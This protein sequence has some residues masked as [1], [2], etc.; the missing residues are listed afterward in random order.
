[1]PRRGGVR[2]GFRSRLSDVANDLGNC[3]FCNST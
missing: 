3:N 2:V 1:V